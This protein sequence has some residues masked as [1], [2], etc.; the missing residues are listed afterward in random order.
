MHGCIFKGVPNLWNMSLEGFRT[1]FFILNNNNIT[2]LNHIG[3][4]IFCI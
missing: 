2:Q 3:K 1:S 4:N